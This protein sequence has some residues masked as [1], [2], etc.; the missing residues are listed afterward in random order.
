MLR[1]ILGKFSVVDRTSSA[2]AFGALYNGRTCKELT[3]EEER[4]RGYIEDLTMR[5]D[6]AASVMEQLDLEEPFY[7]RVEWIR[8]VAALANSFRDDM[9]RCA[10]GR[11]AEYAVGVVSE[12]RPH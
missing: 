5:D 10:L 3:A 9:T 12:Q 8:A 7:A 1:K 6:D 11:I 4:Y 2:S